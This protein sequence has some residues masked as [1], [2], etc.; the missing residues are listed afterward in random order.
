MVPAQIFSST[1]DLRADRPSRINFRP[2]EFRMS[3]QNPLLAALAKASKRTLATTEPDSVPEIVWRLLSTVHGADATPGT[4][5]EILRGYVTGLVAPH[6]TVGMYF[7][8]N[9]S[10]DFGLPTRKAWSWDEWTMEH[11]Q[12][13]ELTHIGTF[14][15]PRIRAR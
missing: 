3:E 9:T 15:N 6:A 13:F 11:T 1:E 5:G 10:P 4:V 2:P 12:I 14:D 7:L 8:Y